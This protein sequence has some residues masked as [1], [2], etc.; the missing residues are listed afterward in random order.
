MRR[1]IVGLTVLAATL[2]VV[3]FGLPL[4][5]GAAQLTVAEEQASLQRLAGVTARSVQTELSH[6]DTPD[7]IPEGDGDT[8]IAVYD[9]DG[10]LIIG[11]GPDTGDSRVRA[12]L[13][14]RTT[15][16]NDDGT[17][18]VTVPVT[19]EHAVHGAVRVARPVADIY[20]HLVPAW[21]GMLALG[22]LVLVLVWQ[23]ARRQARRLAEP[24]ETLSVNARRLGDGDFGVRSPSAGIPEIDAV[25]QALNDTAER[26]D[27]LLARERA[28]SAE[29]SHQLRTPL[30]GLRLRLES[31]LTMS[32][33]ESRR[34]VHAGI[35]SADQLERTIDELM[36]LAREPASTRGE[37]VDVAALTADVLAP[38]RERL[39]AAGRALDETLEADLSRAPVSAAAVRQVLGVLL[40]NAELHGR[41]TVHVTVRDTAGAVAVDVADD[42]DGLDPGALTHTRNGGMGLGLARRLAE[43][44]GGRLVL[45]RPSPPVFTLLL[46]AAPQRDVDRDAPRQAA[47][48]ESP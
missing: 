10:D 9:D 26:L 46:P 4:A 15:Q 43:A 47:P 37:P 40:D 38:R 3:L 31:A 45:T 20:H 18:I 33:E 2:A 12:A 13:Q 48:A 28:F 11:S 1:R 22:A 24:L 35:A 14:G 34:A 27:A 21:L 25:G 7:E 41:G 16:G 5:V 19:G 39:V 17:L 6:G 32:D 36:L 30:A 42:G 44:E 29:A 8:E 23:L